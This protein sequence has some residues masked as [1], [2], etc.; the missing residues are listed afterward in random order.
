MHQTSLIVNADDFGYFDSV[1]RGIMHAIEA[2]GVT[3]TGVMANSAGLS[4]RLES[5]QG[6]NGSVDLG[7]HLNLSLG[8]PVTRSMRRRL[9]RWSGR[10]PTK[11]TVAVAVLRGAIP[12]DDVRAEWIAQIERCLE[13]GVDPWFLNSHEHIHMLPPLYTVAHELAEEYEIPHVRCVSPDSMTSVPRHGMFR[14]LVAGALHHV[15][16]KRERA[17]LQLLGLGASGKL[18]SEYIRRRFSTLQPGRAYELMCH[19]GYYDPA[20]ISEQHLIRYHDWESELGLLT[21]RAFE[22]ICTE[23]GIRVIGYRDL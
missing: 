3:A 23:H 9:G 12:I 1:S 14:N 19:P 15:N 5:L 4:N 7:V 11:F 17:S 22:T 6:V 8:K 18:T 20:E 21:G 10:F 16:P 13:L 2:G